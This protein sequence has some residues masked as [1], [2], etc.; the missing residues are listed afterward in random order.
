M[1]FNLEELCIPT[2]IV[3]LKKRTDRREHIK[4]QFINKPEFNINFVDACE[5]EVG[6]MG[7]W[8]SLVKV[9]HIA[10]N[11]N[12]DVIIFCEDDHLFTQHYSKR[13]L[14]VNII[15]AYQQGADILS[16]GV[17][18]FGTAVPVAK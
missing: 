1:A 11:N 5:N 15:E 2:Y 3:N 6:R 9:I 13:Y 10:E 8:E 18:A 14:V 17:G 4:Q 7:L 16:G 12:D